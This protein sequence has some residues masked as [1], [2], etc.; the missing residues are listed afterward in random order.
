MEKNSKLAQYKEVIRNLEITQLQNSFDIPVGLQMEKQGSISINYIPFDY[1]NT[2]AKIVLVGITPGFT[3]LK[4]A[5]AEAQKKIKAGAEDVEILQA[6]KNTGAFSGAMRTNLV[7]MLDHLKLN[8]L[9]RVDSCDLLFS[10][11]SHLV[12]TTSLLRYPVFVDGKNYN[13]TPNMTKNPLLLKYFTEHFSKEAAALKGAIYIAMGP[14][15]SAS[16]EWLVK[17]GLMDGSSILNGLPHPSGANAERISYFL[18]NKKVNQ[19]SVKT[20]PKIIDIA[21]TALVEKMQR[22]RMA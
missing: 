9:L 10:N 3:Q 15:V 11:E 1:V 6:A 18:G 20:N 22:I 12:H 5:L 14:K 17:Q 8:E 13:G 7:A 21:K 19:L 4:N 2:D 16:L